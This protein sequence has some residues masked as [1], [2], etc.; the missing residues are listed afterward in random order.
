MRT[1]IAYKAQVILS[2][3]DIGKLG[4]RIEVE[5]LV[6]QFVPLFI[7]LSHAFIPLILDVKTSLPVSSAQ[8]RTGPT[9]AVVLLI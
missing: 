2:L 1:N 9:N 5:S 8:Q 7:R 4:V 3:A 6:L